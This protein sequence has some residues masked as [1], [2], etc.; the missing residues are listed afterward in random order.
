MAY[1]IGLLALLVIVFTT[2]SGDVLSPSKSIDGLRAKVTEFIDPK[3]N[4]EIATEKL[5]SEIDSIIALIGETTPDI[6]KSSNISEKN[7]T[8]LT[9]LLETA[10]N[11]KTTAIQI[12]NIESQDS[13][14]LQSIVTNISSLISP[15]DNVSNKD[16]PDP[17][18]IP[19]QCKLICDK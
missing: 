6:L 5:S 10:N 2:I 11:A 12:Q 9:K 3:T 16:L 13:G 1:F 7:K 19:S 18:Y 17:T 8:N 14:L 4:K 15:N